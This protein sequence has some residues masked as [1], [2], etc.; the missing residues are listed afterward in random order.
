MVNLDICNGS[1][2]SLDDP[3]D[4]ICVPNKAEDVHLS[5]FNVITR[6]NEFRH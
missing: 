5:V 4:K 3:S 6:I 1:C 2:N